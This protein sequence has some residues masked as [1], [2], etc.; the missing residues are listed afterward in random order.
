M[1]TAK[2]YKESDMKQ[3]V[4]VTGSNQG[5][6]YEMAKKLSEEHPDTHHIL[7]CSRDLSRGEEAHKKLGSPTNVTPV[8]LDIT[9]DASV[10]TLYTMV[11]SKF[12][13]LDVLIHNAGIAGRDFPAEYTLRQRYEKTYDVNV[14]SPAVMTEKFTP[15]LNKTMLPK[16]IFVSSQLGS[17]GSMAD[18]YAFF[19]APWYG[20]SKAAMNYHAVFFARKYPNWRS[21]AVCPG[22][23]VTNLNGLPETDDTKPSNGAIRAV[24]LALENASSFTG[25]FSNKEGPLEW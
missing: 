15:L 25:K 4:I 13:K 10:D 7:L 12:G 3:L 16:V 23:N 14:I 8:Q 18:G 17:I 21:N 2:F 19:P 24:Q 5:L 11:E 20:S 1:S 6:G 22:L 9:N